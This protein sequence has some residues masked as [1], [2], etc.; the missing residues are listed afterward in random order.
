MRTIKHVARDA[1]GARSVGEKSPTTPRSAGGDFLHLEA[2]CD[3]ALRH[4]FRRQIGRRHQ[5][6]VHQRTVRH[7]AP[8]RYESMTEVVVRLWLSVADMRPCYAATAGSAT[9][10]NGRTRNRRLTVATDGLNWAAGEGFLA[11]TALVVALR[12]LEDVG[13]STVIITLEVGRR[14]FAA[15]VTVECTDRRRNRHLQRSG[16][17]CLRENM[18]G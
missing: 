1:V 3:A 11:K 4:D 18:T 9:G 2:A 7:A 5:R 12:L 13:V 16:G 17:I 14:G 6:V 10:K 8:C 15:E